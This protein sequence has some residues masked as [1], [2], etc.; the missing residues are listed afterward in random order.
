[1]VEFYRTKSPTVSIKKCCQC[2]IRKSIVLVNTQVIRF[3]VD[4]RKFVQDERLET[5][6]QN[7][8]QYPSLFE[9]WQI[10]WSKKD[11]GIHDIGCNM[12]FP[13]ELK[14]F[15]QTQEAATAAVAVCL[16]KP[17]AIAHSIADMPKKR[18]A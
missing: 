3:Y 7:F 18:L 10:L 9:V 11:M 17:S 12:W 16:S 13:N 6:H 1:M 2:P 8:N 4:Q 14:S 15:H 5:F